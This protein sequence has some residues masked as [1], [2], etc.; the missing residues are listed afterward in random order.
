[1]LR[2]GAIALPW[3]HPSLLSKRTDAEHKLLWPCSSFLS[4]LVTKG[5]NYQLKDAIT[6]SVLNSHCNTVLQR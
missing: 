6:I 3:R 1:M 5:F 4:P 2:R